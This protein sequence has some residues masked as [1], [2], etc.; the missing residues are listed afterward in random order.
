MLGI[1]LRIEETEMYQR[2]VRGLGTFR[3]VIIHSLDERDREVKLRR[4]VSETLEIAHGRLLR[5]D[6][7]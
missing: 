1:I 5:G 3:E 6:D 4:K 7:Y 2:S